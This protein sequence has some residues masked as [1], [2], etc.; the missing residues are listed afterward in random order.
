MSIIRIIHDKE[1]P[2][3]QINRFTLRDRELSLKSLGL[4]VRCLSYPDNWEFHISKLAKDSNCGTTM[5]YSAIKELIEKRYAIRLEIF[6]KESGMRFQGTEYFFFEVCKT[7][8]EI[9]D[10][11]SQIKKMFPNRGFRHTAILDAE[12]APLRRIYNKKTDPTKNPPPQT[13]PIEKEKEEE[14]PFEKKREIL[15]EIGIV[16]PDPKKFNEFSVEEILIAQQK[17]INRVPNKS[18]TGMVLD[19]LKR[20]DAWPLEEVLSKVKRLALKYNEQIRHKFP[21]A[22][23]KNEELIQNEC[24]MILEENGSWVQISLKNESEAKKD[25]E[26]SLRVIE[27]QK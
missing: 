27:K 7:P 23:E 12:K 4:L 20:P 25:L 3:A 6:D 17:A 8:Q 16:E 2:Y 13:P 9:E 14:E 19:I 10:F 24:L 18:L 21:K 5:I 11:I 26:N 15:Q 22:A 1:N